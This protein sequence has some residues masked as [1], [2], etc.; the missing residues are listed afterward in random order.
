[1][2]W[3]KR[4]LVPPASLRRLPHLRR[5]AHLQLPHLA[6]RRPSRHHRRPVPVHRPRAVHLR[7]PLPS[8]PNPSLPVR[9]FTALPGRLPSVVSQQSFTFCDHLFLGWSD[10]TLEFLGLQ[11]V[12]YVQQSVM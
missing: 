12:T 8:L 10:N 7:H 9:R 11:S 3:R 1:M 5:R 6:L 2:R 4:V